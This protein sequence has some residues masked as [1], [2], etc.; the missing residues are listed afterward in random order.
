MAEVQII[1]Q[2]ELTRAGY[3]APCDRVKMLV[4]HLELVRLKGHFKTSKGCRILF[5][6]TNELLVRFP[7]NAVDVLYYH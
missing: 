6:D 4:T 2:E 7:G 5:S 3:Q 1:K